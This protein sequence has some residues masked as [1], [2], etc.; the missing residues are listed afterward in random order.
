MVNFRLPYF[1]RSPRDFWDRWHIS[2]STWLRDYLYRPLGGN[3]GGLT[4]TCRNLMLTMLLGGLWHGAAWNYVLWGCYHGAILSIHRVL[5]ARRGI[6]NVA[7]GIGV[8]LAKTFGFGLLTL[9]GWLLFRAHSFKQ[10]VQFTRVLFTGAGGLTFGAALP[11][12]SAFLG[13]ILLVAWEIA[14]F[15]SGGSAKFYQ[16][17]PQWQLGFANAAMVFLTFMG[18]SNEPAQFIYFQF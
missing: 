18:M 11:G 3:R 13:V 4:F 8:G 7:D 1:A 14:Q 2:L 15:S 17:I 16:K 6:K 10:I 9:Y 5:V 12:F